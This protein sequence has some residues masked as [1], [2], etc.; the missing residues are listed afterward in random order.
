LWAMSALTGYR[1]PWILHPGLY[2]LYAFFFFLFGLWLVL[3]ILRKWRL[4]K[5]AYFY[6]IRAFFYFALLIL[7]D[8][9]L[10][11]PRLA[12]FP[13]AGLFLISLAG[14][15]RWP[16]LKGL[17]WLLSPVL[18]FRLLVLPEYYEF[19]YRTVG[20]M[21][22]ANVRTT[23]AF[24]LVHLVLILFFILW[25]MPFLLGFAAIY[26]S[27]GA[28]L[29]GLK[30]FRR[31]LA[32]IPIGILIVGGAL[33]LR[34]LPSYDHIWEQEV[35]VTQKYDTGKG[36]T[37]VE[38]SSGDYLRGI[39]A[40]IDGQKETLEAR[41]CS[42]EKKLPF[43]MNWLRTEFSAPGEE[44]G[45]ERLVDLKMLLGFERQPFAVTL[46]L[47][48]NRPFRL[49]EA[50]VQ[51]RHRKNRATVRWFSFPAAP[52]QPEMK[53]ILPRECTLEAE[54]NATFLETPLLILC[55]GKNKAFIHRAELVHK[56]NLLE[57]GR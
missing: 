16:W 52:L 29:F 42:L 48:S 10:A 17:L 37:W 31:P 21:G 35:A 27:S 53:L 15:V 44:K 11:G 4:R 47:K 41:T 49:E 14:L 51:F 3:Q 24:L 43:E 19:V 33:Y 8:W 1:L 7:A 25:T 39:T 57:S 28:D 46:K 50:N 30:R 5:N 22:L 18:M 26:R 54:V 9:A 13:A 45:A 6:F 55:E 56:I 36:E 38:F 40:T 12:V 20:I 32:I 34:T 23:T 2:V